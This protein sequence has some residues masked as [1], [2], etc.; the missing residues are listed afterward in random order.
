MEMPYA[1]SSKTAT[2]WFAD[3]EVPLL[4]W[5]ANS[6]DLNA[7]ENIQGTVK[8]KMKSTGP[9]DTEKLKATIKATRALITSPL[10][11]FKPRH[12]CAVTRGKGGVPA[13][14]WVYKWTCLSETRHFCILHHFLN[15]WDIRFLIYW[16]ALKHIGS[17]E[18]ANSKYAQSVHYNVNE[19]KLC[20]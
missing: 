13:K 7:I 12:T 1:F 4:D 3:H 6:P 19:P 20:K 16:S 14:Y 5:P 15:I 2:R 18:Y 10:M 11:A 8:S 9:S 17:E